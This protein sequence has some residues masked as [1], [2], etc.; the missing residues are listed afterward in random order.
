MTAVPNLD[1]IRLAASRL[2]GIHQVTPLLECERLNVRVDGRV[3]VKPECLQ[4]VGAFKLRGAY[5]RLSQLD[6]TKFPGGVVTCSSGN[7]A[8]GVAEAARLLG[9][10]AVIVMP[11]DAPAIKLARTKSMGG[12]VVTYDRDTEDREAIAQQ[13]AEDRNADYV[14]PYDDPLIIAGQGTVGL[15]FCEQVA[16]QGAK[17]D[18]VLVPCGGGGLISGVTLAVDVLIPDADIY[19]VE[20]AG[21][22]DLARS[23]VSGR[24]ERNEAVSGSICDALLAPQP[25]A[26]PFEILR[27][28]LK[29]GLVVS[30]DEVRAAVRFA[31]EE[32]KLVVEPGGAVTL[33]ALLSGKV[34]LNGQTAV[35]VLSGGNVDPQTFADIIV[36]G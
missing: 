24:I 1:D 27:S 35:I 17:A 33:A 5:N 4:R 14:S 29:S 11:V 20:P 21:F 23:L 19:S 36:D 25:G 2:Q 34:K 9:I 7:H 28:R 31:F 10:P 18:M 12:E 8:Q 6:R 30:D 3:L 26:I 22:D 32:L 15:E 16:A 13:I